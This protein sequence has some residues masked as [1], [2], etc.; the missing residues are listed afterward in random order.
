MGVLCPGLTSGLV[1]Q[2]SLS[3]DRTADLL[4]YAICGIVGRS[5]RHGVGACSMVICSLVSSAMWACP[6]PREKPPLE[7][8]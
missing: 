6:G 1:H 2:L 3:C 8:S 5:D 4:G 7:T